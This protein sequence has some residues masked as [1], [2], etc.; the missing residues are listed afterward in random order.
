MTYVR[1]ERD[2]VERALT[3]GR[4]FDPGRLL[5]VL[6]PSVAGQLPRDGDGH[7]HALTAGTGDGPSAGRGTAPHELGPGH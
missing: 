7:R 5:P 3:E 4:R 6:P 1:R 2:W